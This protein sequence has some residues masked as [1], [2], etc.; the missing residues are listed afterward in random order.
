MQDGVVTSG[1]CEIRCNGNGLAA[2][3]KCYAYDFDTTTNRCYVFLSSSYIRN[4]V[5]ASPGIDHYM[6]AGN[7]APGNCRPFFDFL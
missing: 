3:K 4:A 6:K 1:A 5:G 2:G 7:C